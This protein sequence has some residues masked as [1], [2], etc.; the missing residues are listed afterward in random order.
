MTKTAT[1]KPELENG[2]AF[3]SSEASSNTD[4]AETVRRC[5]VS[6]KTFPKRELIRFCVSPDRELVPDLANKLPGRGIWVRADADAV[7]TAMT[8]GLFAKVAGSKVTYPDDLVE[9]VRALFRRR[10]AD[11]LGVAKKAGL[12][13]SGFEKVADALRKGKLAWLLEA[14]DG[15]DDGREKILRLAKDVS[16]LYFLS[17]GETAH[18]LGREHSVHTGL[19]PGGATDAFIAEAKRCM[20]FEK[21]RTFND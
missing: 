19:K 21:K 9:R 12:V 7:Q 6:G 15:A 5:I 2:E 20:A 17:S 1:P 16:V 3:A 14:E 10:C 13:V 8:K 11:L 18:A 4:K